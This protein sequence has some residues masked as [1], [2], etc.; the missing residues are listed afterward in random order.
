MALPPKAIEQLGR[1]PVRT[2]GWSGRILMFSSTLFFLSVATYFGIIFGYKPFLTS[3]LEAV[4]NETRKFSQQ[5][6]AAEQENIIIFYSQLVNLRT[7][8]NK[9]KLA[10]LAFPWLEQHTH[11]GVYWSSF[12]LNVDGGSI[13]V[14]GQA[15]TLED[16]AQQLVSLQ[17]LP[18]IEDVEFSGASEG[19]G[20]FWNFSLNIRLDRDFLNAVSPTQE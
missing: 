17:G 1:E 3:R 10:S 12:S 7:L 16:L 8:L 14:S 20:D 11:R 4:E 6:P 15:R 2:P 19:A 18:E 13:N 9:Q 5:V